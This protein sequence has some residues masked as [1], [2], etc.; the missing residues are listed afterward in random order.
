[1]TDEAST[2]LHPA[3]LSTIASSIE[4]FR[5]EAWAMTKAMDHRLAAFERNVEKSDGS[6]VKSLSEEALRISAYARRALNAG[7]VEPTVAEYANTSALL[8]P[9]G[10]DNAR[11][12]GRGGSFKYDPA[13]L[14]VNAADQAVIDS[15][16]PL[17][18]SRGPED[19]AAMMP[20]PSRGRKGRRSR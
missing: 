15:L 9:R 4:A 10:Y 17:V 3:T 2:A 16:R 20:L 13:N 5:E 1:V 14:V 7:Q 19:L 11:R 8:D 12:D 6:D 18:R